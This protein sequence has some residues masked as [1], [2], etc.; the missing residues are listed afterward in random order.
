MNKADFL[1]NNAVFLFTASSVAGSMK[2]I[3]S[4]IF[5]TS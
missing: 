2:F 4:S 3:F 1:Y 5:K